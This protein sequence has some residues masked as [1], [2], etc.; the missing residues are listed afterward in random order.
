MMCQI[1][2]IHMGEKKRSKGKEE[3][4]CA[5]ERICQELV[6]QLTERGLLSH[7]WKWAISIF[8]GLLVGWH[9]HK[10]HPTGSCSRRGCA[11]LM[12][13]HRDARP[14][15][16]EQKA[17]GA[18]AQGSANKSK[19]GEGRWNWDG[20]KQHCNPASD[21]RRTWGLLSWAAWQYSALNPAGSTNPSQPR[22]PLFPV[23]VAESDIY[24][25]KSWC[26]A[27][28]LET[29]HSTATLRYRPQ[30]QKSFWH[31]YRKRSASAVGSY[32][33]INFT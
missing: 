17:Q 7:A 12:P 3:V 22:L 25:V 11:V 28:P 6:C 19:Q 30:R 8:E 5:H 9:P 10:R 1:S 16:R 15:G 13:R 21:S 23:Q 2:C 32:I 27:L 33:P 18:D 26:K 4:V 20:V 31:R 24:T 14:R 29:C